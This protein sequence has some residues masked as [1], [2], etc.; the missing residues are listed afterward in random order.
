MGATQFCKSQKANSATYN[1]VEIE[2]F[3]CQVEEKC[4]Y[5]ELQDVQRNQ[6]RTFVAVLPITESLHEKLH[7]FFKH[8]AACEENSIASL[9]FEFGTSP[10]PYRCGNPSVWPVI[11]YDRPLNLHNLVMKR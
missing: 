3:V 5:F 2:L 4:A 11:S 8:V 9:P 7:D 10:L 1:L 6:K